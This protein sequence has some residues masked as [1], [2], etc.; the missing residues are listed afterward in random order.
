MNLF[1][2]FSAPEVEPRGSTSIWFTDLPF[3]AIVIPDPDLGSSCGTNLQEISPLPLLGR[4]DGK[5]AIS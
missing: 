1:T 4:N 5:R 3:M 2:A